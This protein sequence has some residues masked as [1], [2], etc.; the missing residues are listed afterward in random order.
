MVLALPQPPQS[1][2]HTSIAHV[3]KP[4]A[5]NAHTHTQYVVRV[6][7]E[8]NYGFTWTVY[9]R[10]SEFRLF[11][12]RLEEAVKQGDMCSHCSIMSKRTSFM[13]FPH[14][15]LFWN[16]K[17]KVLESRRFGLNAFL[18]AVAKH[19][20]T[21]RESM[22]CKTRQLMDQFLDVNDMRYTYL[23]VNMSDSEDDG[24]NKL[25]L[26]S[27]SSAPSASGTNHNS[28]FAATPTRGVASR[29]SSCRDTRSNSVENG[30]L[31]QAMNGLLV[32][33]QALDGSLLAESFFAATESSMVADGAPHATTASRDSSSTDHETAY[34]GRVVSSRKASL[35]NILDYG[36]SSRSSRTSFHDD[37]AAANR[38]GRLSDWE[39]AK[40]Q[41]SGA[42]RHS[43]PGTRNDL[44]SFASSTGRRSEHHRSRSRRVH[45]SSAAKRVKKLEEQEARFNSHP[46]ARKKKVAVL[47]TITE[48]ED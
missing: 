23:N 19:A 35:P 38:P 42:G 24:R 32:D 1:V 9:R 6:S 39:M 14:R 41:T 31:F 45:L 4:S 44:L 15:R 10:Y 13:Q 5:S 8:R 47:A 20:R 12:L 11:R 48:E 29:T 18:E 2:L 33:N 17:E 26:H 40:Y 22:T 34:D 27:T 28:M 36:R 25:F 43:D 16:T 37:V 21:C 7:D 3:T 46:P 30:S